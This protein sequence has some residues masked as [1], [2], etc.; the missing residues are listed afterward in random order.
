MGFFV[1][2]FW[3]LRQTLAK[4]ELIHIPGSL[5]KVTQSFERAD[6]RDSKLNGLRTDGTNSEENSLYEH[7]LKF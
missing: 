5:E 1:L 3:G 6:K 2:S 7:L 4:P